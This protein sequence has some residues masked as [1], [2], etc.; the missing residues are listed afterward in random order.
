MHVEHRGVA[1]RAEILD[2][3]IGDDHALLAARELVK[4]AR[5]VALAHVE[6]GDV[7]LM[8]VAGGIA[9]QPHAELIVRE[10]IA[11]EIAVEVL[12][13]GADRHE[14]ERRVEHRQAFFDERLF[15]AVGL[16][17]ALSD[18]VRRPFRLPTTVARTAQL[19]GWNTVV[20]AEQLE[21]A[22]EVVVV[23]RLAG[24]RVFTGADLARV[25]GRIHLQREIRKE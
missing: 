13:A 9:E 21:P 20:A 16:P 11:A 25:D 3:V 1:G 18:P 12:H 7:V 2:V 22:D 5:R 15:H 19:F 14:V 8:A 23:E 4:L 6:V 17:R 24:G 10:Q